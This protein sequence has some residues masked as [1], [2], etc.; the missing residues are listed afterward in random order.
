M[1][2]RILAL[3]GALVTLIITKVPALEPHRD[4]L[5]QILAFVA[6]WVWAEIEV[7]HHRRMEHV[8]LL[9]VTAGLPPT[10][11]ITAVVADAILDKI[12]APP[13]RPT[14]RL[15]ELAKSKLQPAVQAAQPLDP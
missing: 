2:P 7:R 14:V 4:I 9:E 13:D 15:A 1:S 8:K 6:L 11:K 10:G 5:V 3:I 12:S